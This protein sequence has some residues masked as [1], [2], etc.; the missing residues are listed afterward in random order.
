MMSSFWLASSPG[1]VED[2]NAWTS[3]QAANTAT[4]RQLNGRN[5]SRAFDLPSKCGPLLFDVRVVFAIANRKLDT[6]DIA[7]SIA[8]LTKLGF[9]HVGVGVLCFMHSAEVCFP[10]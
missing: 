1:V 5:A 2:T 4:S 6:L 3:G 9:T 7:E 10:W 8:A